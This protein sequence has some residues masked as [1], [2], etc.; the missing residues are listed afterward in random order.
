MIFVTIKKLFPA[1]IV[2]TATAAA[3]VVVVVVDFVFVAVDFAALVTFKDSIRIE[4]R[5]AK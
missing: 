3:A 5:V 2:V 1:F 4:N